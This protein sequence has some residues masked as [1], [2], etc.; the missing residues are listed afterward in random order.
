LLTLCDASQ[1][2]HIVLHISQKRHY[3]LKAKQSLLFC[4]K[5][6]VWITG[7]QIS[8]LGLCIDCHSSIINSS[9]SW[10]TVQT[11]IRVWVEHREL[12]Q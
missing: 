3:L 9:S 11:G 4:N 6:Y 12:Q 2:I 8:Q 5:L 1:I 10:I 7:H